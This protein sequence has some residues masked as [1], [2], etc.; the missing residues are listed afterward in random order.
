VDDEPK[1]VASVRLYL[2]HAGYA[3]DTAADGRAAR[4]SLEFQRLFPHACMGA[5]VLGDLVVS[6]DQENRRLRIARPAP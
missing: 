6:F 4:P 2:E 5:E 3:V 1:T